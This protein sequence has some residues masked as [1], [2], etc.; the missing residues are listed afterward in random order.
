M[1]V[2]PVLQRP[3]PLERAFERIRSTGTAAADVE[4]S[5]RA[6]LEAL[7]PVMV[8]VWPEVAWRFGLLTATG[9]PVELAWASRDAGLR[10]TC[11]VAGPETPEADRLALAAQAAH[12]EVAPWAAVQQG[13]HLRYG[14]WLGVGQLDGARR[15]KVYLELPTGDLAPGPWAE[16]GRDLARRVLD[17]TWRM[18]GVNDDGSVELYA[19]VPELSWAQLGAAARLAGDQGSLVNLVQELISRPTRGGPGLPRPSGLSLVLSPSHTPVALTWFTV[20]KWVWPGDAA[21]SA[22]VLRTTALVVRRTASREMY[23]ALS[24]GPDDGRWRHGMVGVGVNMAGGTWLQ[25]GL[26]PT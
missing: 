12:V 1:S 11:E 9:Y 18:T 5:E 23:R 20:A 14:A 17:L 13:R 6:L 7:R 25:A 10:W 15:A 3:A 21:V 19:R 22:A 2:L 8:S 26:R 4:S 24:S 16:A